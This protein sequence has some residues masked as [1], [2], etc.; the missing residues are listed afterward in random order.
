MT[1]GSTQATQG[2]RLLDSNGQVVGIN[3]ASND[4]NQYFAISRDVATPL[5]EEMLNGADVGSLGINGEAIILGEDVTGIWISS[6]QSGSP[7]DAVGILP[8]DILLSIEGITLA[9]DGTMSTYCEILHSHSPE[10]V[11]AVEILRLDTEEVLAGQFNGR[12]LAQSFSIAET[13]DETNVDSPASSQQQD[14]YT[15]FVEISDEQG[16]LS[17]EVPASWQHVEEL[18]WLM[19]DDEVGIVLVATPDFDAFESGWETPGALLRYSTALAG[20]MDADDLLDD[21]DYS[22]NCTFEGRSLLDEGYFQGAYDIWSGCG[23]AGSSALIMAL[24]PEA[25]D[26]YVVRIETYSVTDADLEVIDRVLDTFQVASSE[27][28]ADPLLDDQG[29][30][31]Y[32]HHRRHQHFGIGI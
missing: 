19:G 15:D 27:Q 32:A 9:T 22:D 18:V 26:D 1:R 17:A 13:L 31:S 24:I 20:Q 3:Y 11:M 12:P 5:L 23:D 6:V 30:N 21:V 7:A 28:E 16:I 14:A 4:A 10:D 29:T 2:D 25:P 8:G